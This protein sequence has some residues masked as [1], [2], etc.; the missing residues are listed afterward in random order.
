M[1]K[2]WIQGMNL[3]KGALRAA[4]QAAGAL[5]PDGTI[6]KEWLAKKAKGKGLEAKRARLAQIFAKLRKK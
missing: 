6:N 4:A 2:K 3:K 5:N 1:A